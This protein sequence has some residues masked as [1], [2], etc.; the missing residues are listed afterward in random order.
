MKSPESELVAIQTPAGGELA[1]G[2][3]SG[4]LSDMCDAF[5][6]AKLILAFFYDNIL[7]TIMEQVTFLRDDNPTHRL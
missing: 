7:P 3:I 6:Y 5:K 2:T 4:Y 1:G